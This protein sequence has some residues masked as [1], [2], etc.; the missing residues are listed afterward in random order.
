MAAVGT[1]KNDRMQNAEPKIGRPFMQQPTFDW[2]AKDKYSKL[3]N[4]IKEVN[5]IFECYNM[6][7]SERIVITKCG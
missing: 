5:N 7:Q 6:P 3:R 4:Y 1:D 2:E